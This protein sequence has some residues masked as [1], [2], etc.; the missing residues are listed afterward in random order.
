MPLSACRET[1]Q[2]RGLFYEIA[3]G[4]TGA[5]SERAA[6]DVFLA[7]GD[8]SDFPRDGWT[9]PSP[10]GVFTSG[11]ATVTVVKPP[12]STTWFVVEARTC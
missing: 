9:G 12:D 3:S 10:S 11:T 5:A 2:C 1:P 7:S 6:L 4:A 8:S